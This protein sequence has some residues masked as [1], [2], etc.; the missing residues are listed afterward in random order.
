MCTFLFTHKNKLRLARIKDLVYFNFLQN[1]PL[2]SSTLPHKAFLNSIPKSGTNLLIKAIYHLPGMHST[3]LSFHSEMYGTPWQPRRPLRQR[4]W[5]WFPSEKESYNLARQAK[6]EDGMTDLPSS[7]IPIGGF[8]KVFVPKESLGEILALISP[9][10]FFDGHMPYS[11]AFEHLLAE[12]NFKSIF[13]IRDPRDTIVSEINFLHRESNLALHEHY[14]LM[15]VEE[16][17]L[18][19]IQGFEGEECRYPRQPSFREILLDYIPW[20]SKPNVLVTRFEDLVGPQGGGSVHS[21]IEQIL[22]IAHH[23]EVS[24]SPKEAG[25]IAKS[26]FGGTHT[27]RR[28]VKGAWKEDFSPEVKDRCKHFLGDLLIQLGYEKDYSW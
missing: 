18:S 11:V 21:Q 28:G 12:G 13:I 6:L 9:G 26:L 4:I 1:L 22:L 24:I 25:N 2:F 16:G 3:T 19:I 14:K 7:F 23:L 15:E 20:I 5:R 10:S 8:H 27:F 17:M